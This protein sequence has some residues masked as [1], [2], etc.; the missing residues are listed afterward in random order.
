MWI[1]VY[2]PL[3]HFFYSSIVAFIPILMMFT[4]LLLKVKGYIAGFL[5]L[6]VTFIIT[7]F[8]WEF[9]FIMAIS[10]VIYG[11]TFSIFPIFLILYSTIFLFNLTKASGYFNIIKLSLSQLTTD[12]RLQLLL[13]GFCFTNFLD[14]TAGFV[15]PVAIV[16]AMLVGLGF[17]PI[18]AASLALVA[19]SLPAA[20]GGVGIPLVILSQVTGL[21]LQDLSIMTGRQIPLISLI[22][23]SWLIVIMGGFKSIKGIEIHILVVSLSFAISQWLISN[24]FSPFLVAIGSS[25]VSLLALIGVIYLRPIKE[26]WDFMQEKQDIRCTYRYNNKINTKIIIKSWSPFLILAL[27]I[28]V[29][30]FPHIQYILNTFTFRIPFTTL[31]H[32][33][34]KVPPIAPS[35]TSEEVV[36]NFNWASSAGTAIFISLL[37]ATPLLKISFC[38]WKRQA[39]DSLKQ[40]KW[41]WFTMATVNGIAFLM[42]YSGMAVTLGLA[43]AKTGSLF[44]FLSPAIAWL[45]TFLVGSNTISNAMFGNLQVATART[46]GLSPVLFAATN[47]S[48]A[49]AGKMIAPNQLTAAASSVELPGHEGELF[50]LVFK[51]SILFVIMVG[52]ITWIESFLF[53]FIIP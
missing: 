44:P 50:K 39:I 16:S 22:F 26:P 8:V 6:V 25:L 51:H 45:G 11:I 3:D 47:G 23:P 30:N 4:L 20:F 52:F 49:V 19:S 18:L 46:M 37:L 32:K 15:A 28:L 38:E 36:F 43:L 40:L 42:N 2:N 9:P 31:N 29:W 13:I 1:Q 24:Y 53:A 48:G 5:T 41:T 21:P 7:N 17:N 34:L 10:S 14:A 35:P 12:K 27:I 33:I